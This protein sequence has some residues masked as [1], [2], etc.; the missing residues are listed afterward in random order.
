MLFRS[1]VACKPV[2]SEFFRGAGKREMCVC[3]CARARMCLSV[4]VKDGCFT[5]RFVLN[6]RHVEE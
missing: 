5:G 6:P 2:H 1:L 3:V 4:G